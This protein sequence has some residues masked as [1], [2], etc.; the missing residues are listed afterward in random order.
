MYIKLALEVCDVI[1]CV[2]SC[3]EGD[4][5]WLSWKFGWL[6]V[7]KNIAVYYDGSNT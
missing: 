6:W 3:D 5:E 4:C 2:V 1:G 7:L